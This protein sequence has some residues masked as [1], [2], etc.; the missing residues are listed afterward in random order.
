MPEL[1]MPEPAIPELAMPEGVMPELAKPLVRI[2]TGWT[3]P[4]YAAV[5]A[6]RSGARH[7]RFNPSKGH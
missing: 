7:L 6:P 4:K 5:G 3:A 2:A 1:A